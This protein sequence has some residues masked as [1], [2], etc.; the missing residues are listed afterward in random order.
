LAAD[1][2]DAPPTD[3]SSD[4]TPA[5]RVADLVRRRGPVPL[6]EVVDIAL[7]DPA[8]GFYSSAARGAGR[9]GD[10]LTSP[11]VG[12]L[13][14][15]IVARALDGWWRALDTPDPFVVVDAG[16]GPGTLA[17][18][19]LAAEPDCA[20]ALRYVLVDRSA[21]QREH[22]RAYL[23]LAE[24]AQVLAPRA[25]GPDG[26]DVGVPGG[27][28][29]VVSLPDLPRVAAH[30]VFANELLDNLAFRLYE[31]TETGWAEVCA[32]LAPD[33]DVTLVEH[34]VPVETGTV[35]F[36]DGLAVAVGRRV[37]RQEAAA[38]WLRAALAIVPRGRVVVI[39]YVSTT[40]NMA[41]R[42]PDEWLR[43]YRGHE[44]GGPLLDALGDQDITCEVAVDQ[45]AAVR[46]P[47]ADTAQRDWIRNHDSAALVEEGRR[48]W[49]ERAAIGDLAALKA[50]SRV[51]EA[52]ALEDPAGLGA[53]RVLE[54][55]V[56]Q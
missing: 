40:T 10:F 24:P 37:P 26:E 53:F 13:F 20:A 11:E 52:E 15:A 8:H 1:G 18:S 17:R 29:V 50:R 30:V 4:A 38:A 54:W 33:D 48:I 34:L 28:P 16:A 56:G 25:S 12:P 2:G 6:D 9:R 7:Y 5:A 51:R 42:S 35:P 22:H 41:A 31:R 46:P 23:P 39:D 3:A 49:E 47:D 21:G 43:T 45:L 32:G 27:G 19:V 36:L 55:V 14:G 44:R